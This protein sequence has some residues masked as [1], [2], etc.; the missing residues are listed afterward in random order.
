MKPLPAEQ[1]EMNAQSDRDHRLRRWEKLR[2]PRE[3][4][5]V[6]GEGHRRR[7]AH[8]G[9]SIATNGLGHHRLG[10][11]VQKRYWSAVGRNRIKRCL[12]EFFRLNKHRIPL[13]GKD[14]VLIARPGAQDLNP[15]RMAAE[16]LPVLARQEGR[17]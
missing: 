13:P 6:K 15:A 12:R 3:F 17:P 16:L 8:F 4:E 10:L 7:T 1:A 14:V 11:V 2:Q 9:I 5:R